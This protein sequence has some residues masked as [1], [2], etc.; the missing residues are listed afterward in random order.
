MYSGNP[1]EN[2][3]TKNPQGT[4]QSYDEGAGGCD[5]DGG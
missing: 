2:E 5:C 4:D 3:K 1:K